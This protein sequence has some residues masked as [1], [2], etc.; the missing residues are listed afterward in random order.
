[1]MVISY[2]YL[3]RGDSPIT[4]PTPL[5]I[6]DYVQGHSLLAGRTVVV[7]AGAG[8]GIVSVAA[9]GVPDEDAKAVIIGDIHEGSLDAV[10]AS[11]SEEFGSD[12]VASVLSDVSSE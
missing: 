1:M 4:S 7:T 10:A 12:R 3:G 8:A 9:K 11:L 2:A 5:E 6:P